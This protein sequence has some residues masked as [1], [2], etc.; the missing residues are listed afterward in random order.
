MV[1]TVLSEA[2]TA[3]NPPTKFGD[4]IRS[5]YRHR[6]SVQVYSREI[7][8]DSEHENHVAEIWCVTCVTASESFPLDST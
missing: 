2:E 1:I 8:T 4:S 7:H 6:Y 5:K 3:G